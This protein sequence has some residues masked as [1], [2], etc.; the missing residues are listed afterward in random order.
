MF[1]RISSTKDLKSRSCVNL[2]AKLGVLLTLADSL[3][4]EIRRI[5]IGGRG[6][7]LCAI[8]GRRVLFLDTDADRATQYDRVLREL[9]QVP[10]IDSV[11]LRPEVREDLDRIA[12]NQ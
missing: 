11:Y 1:H 10:E 5:P 9:A 8:K 12:A 4:I 2:D 3:G 6:G 7:T